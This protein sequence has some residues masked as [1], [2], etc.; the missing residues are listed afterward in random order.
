VFCPVSYLVALEAGPGG[1][2]CC[3]ARLEVGGGSLRAG[4]GNKVRV[5]NNWVRHLNSLI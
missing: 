2:H 4:L 1:V 3:P 5:E